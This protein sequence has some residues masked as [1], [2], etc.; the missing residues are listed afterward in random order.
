MTTEKLILVAGGYGYGNAGDE[1][2]CA[3]TLHCL[4][5]R[6][7][8]CQIRNLT[9]RP[10]YSARAHPGFAHDLASRAAVFRQGCG[11]NLFRADT[12]WRRLRFRLR[13]AWVLF[14]AKLA[15]RGL[16]V[17][18]D[19]R[20]A[21][22]VNLVSRAS[23]FFFCGGGYM[24]GA[25]RTRL[26]DGAFI[27]RL[28]RIFGVPVVMSGQT[29]GEW[30]DALDRR[31]ARRGF[32]DVAVIATRDDDASP[33]DLAD[34]GFPSERVLPT[35]DDAL[36]CEK[37]A[38]RELASGPYI[39]VNF[40]FWKLPE[41]ERPAL[42]ARLR[43]AFDQASR[44]LPGRRFAFVPMVGSDKDA[45]NAFCRDNPDFAIELFDGGDDFRR[46][47]R[48]FADADLV[49]TMKHHPIIFA[50]GEGTPVVS[51]AQSAYYVHKNVGALEQ[52]GLGACS[53]DLGSQD[54]ETRFG[55]ALAKALDGDWFKRTAA[56][57]RDVVR[58]R[59]AEFWRRVDMLVP[60]GS[61]RKPSAGTDRDGRG[62]ADALFDVA[63]RHVLDGQRGAMPPSPEATGAAVYRMEYDIVPSVFPGM[64][65]GRSAAEL[66]ERPEWCFLWSNGVHLNNEL[67]LA[68]AVRTGA[69]LV[70]CEDG[71]LRSADTWANHAAPPRYRHGCSLVLD[72]QG[73]YY[74]AT[75]ESTVERMLNDPDLVVSEAERREAR[76][77][78]DRI[79]G[80]KLTKYN[81]QP[82]DVPAVGRPG[83]RKVLV[84]DQ[85]YGDFAIKK[86]WAD[87]STFERM[88][89]DAIRDN[90]DADVIVKTHPDTM[91]GRRKGY[92]DSL[93]E[94]DNVFRA[95]M[96]VNP[97]SLM[98]L[99]D[100]VY[101]C[102]TQFGFEALMAGKEVHV[103]GMPFYAG[104]GLTHDR[105][106]NPRRTRTR[107][108][109]EV[110][111][112]FYVLYT[113]W[114]NPDTGKPCAID[115]AI[116][117]LLNVRD[118]WRNVRAGGNGR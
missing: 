18:L 91:T 47:R 52:Y 67:V 38:V 1:A 20:A 76:R 8:D 95:T 79:V 61:V 17:F 16:P 94:H 104:W 32:A 81:H 75:R 70:L 117:W 93:K 87:D 62:V 60:P 68:D 39:A 86:G 118:E 89:A 115:E 19:A 84:V 30:S 31:T 64:R 59:E 42:L 15:R 53:V 73:C 78:I 27:C 21:A 102:S 33:R 5:L 24:T 36:F 107:T 28:C 10:D 116:G 46:I 6:Y 57:G 113:R 98:E 109:E 88:L 112:I 44:S 90:P 100:K 82:L 23:L 25:T 110:F 13:A 3:A 56:A 2:Q 108:L 96:P 66:G 55:A 92:Y 43:T 22:F 50:I 71:F 49:L 83:R 26:W 80:E 111:Y 101:V 99:V 4:A 37:A 105:Q 69:R 77:L 106:K 72:T 74:D 11:R 29:I 14:N 63:R 65:F 51:L 85:S 45:F 103:Y 12:P 41:A 40:H 54:W 48:V 58:A 34:V 35:H 9:P 7:P 114:Y 97:Y